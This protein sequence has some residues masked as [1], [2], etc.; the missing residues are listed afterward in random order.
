MKQI[1]FF[2][3]LEWVCM[4]AYSLSP[5]FAL[6][7]P[8]FCVIMVFAS[9]HLACA[10]LPLALIFLYTHTHTHTHTH[11]YTYTNNKQTNTY[12]MQFLQ[13]VMSSFTAP[14]GFP[15]SAA[16]AA[17]G[18]G[19]GGG[20]RTSNSRGTTTAGGPPSRGSNGSSG[21]AAA[22]AA[23]AAAG[24][25]TGA[26][27]GGPGLEVPVEE[28]P[29]LLTTFGA[30]L[31]RLQ[32]ADF[33]PTPMPLSSLALSACVVRASA[34]VRVCIC[35]SICVRV[36]CMVECDLLPHLLSLYRVQLWPCTHSQLIACSCTT[37]VLVY[38]V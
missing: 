29:H 17:A 23:A 33:N 32:S 38:V 36:C 30:Y 1:I 7:I 21:A 19:G 20:N 11:I 5:I 10:L 18:G 2:A 27:L 12:R 3:K 4:F 37:R 31:Q 6:G 22:A 24:G 28:M 9:W 26:G 16:T 15:P 13:G 25:H 34:S 35:L 8:C 14:P